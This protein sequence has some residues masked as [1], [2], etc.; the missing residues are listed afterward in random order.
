MPQF[1]P[2]VDRLC[3]IAHRLSI[4]LG[5][6]CDANLINGADPV[7]AFPSALIY[8]RI[9][10]IRSFAELEYELNP[11][12]FSFSNDQRSALLLKDYP[13]HI[14]HALSEVLGSLREGV[15]LLLRLWG[16]EG[17]CE[18]KTWGYGSVP[19]EPEPTPAPV[20]IYATGHVQFAKPTDWPPPVPKEIVDP[21][22]CVLQ[23]LVEVV[24]FVQANLTEAVP[25]SEAG[26]ARVAA[27]AN[28]DPLAGLAPSRQKAYRLYLRAVEAA[29]HLQDATEKDVYNWL[30]NHQDDGDDSLQPYETFTRYLREC[31]NKLGN[32][33]RKPRGGRPT[34]RSIVRSNE[35]EYRGGK[36]D[37]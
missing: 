31:R 15:D 4:F 5:S 1:Y 9:Q 20:T 18:A 34:G 2:P 19:P 35:I 24:T 13:E 10:V 25:S 6:L 27:G 32:Q 3:G 21:L 30:S 14:L 37:S 26:R 11:L 17:L 16:L 7:T 22:Q 29:P 33:K 8:R 36:A 12:R 23:R 28:A